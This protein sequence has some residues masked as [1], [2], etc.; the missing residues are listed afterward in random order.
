M[1]PIAAPVG[2]IPFDAGLA[3]SSVYQVA[4]F[5]VWGKLT[6]RVGLAGNVQR[7]LN[8]VTRDNRGIKSVVAQLRLD[9][10]V[11]DRLTVFARSEFYG[12]NISEFSPLAL[13]RTRYFGGLE[14]ALSRPPATAEEPRRHKPLPAGSSQTQQGEVHPPEER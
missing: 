3:P 5:R 13:A 4:S 7:A 9:Y 1:A 10:K 2:P 11:S 6:N 8:G 12:Q 14:I